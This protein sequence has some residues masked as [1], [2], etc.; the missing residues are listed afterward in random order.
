MGRWRVTALAHSANSKRSGKCHRGPHAGE[1]NGDARRPSPPVPPRTPDSVDRHCARS[2][3]A[4]ASLHQR[5]R[6]RWLSRPCAKPRYPRCSHS[7]AMIGGGGPVGLSWCPYSRALSTTTTSGSMQ[8]VMHALWS[9]PG[10]STRGR[11]PAPPPAARSPSR[12]TR[13]SPR[14]F[15][16]GRPRRGRWGSR[17]APSC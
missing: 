10:W 13:P 1:P 8:D 14:R 7:V 15:P 2:G 16:P 11:R 6:V 3:S 5:V 4:I 17:P 9:R 12:S